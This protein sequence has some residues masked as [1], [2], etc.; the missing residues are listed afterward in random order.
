MQRRERQPPRVPLA[1]DGRAHGLLLL[2]AVRLA[3]AQLG[4]QVVAVRV[5]V[6]LDPGV[7]RAA[8][9]R[10]VPR[11][12]A[13]PAPAA[14]HP[15]AL[16]VRQRGGHALEERRERDVHQRKRL[17]Q[18]VGAGRRA[19]LGVHEVQRVFEP[20]PVLAVRPAAGEPAHPAA[21]QRA[22]ELEQ[23]RRARAL[24]RAVR[25]EHGRLGEGAFQRRRNGGG[26][27]DH[28]AVDLHHRQ[29]PARHLR[30][31]RRLLV[32]VA[33][34]VDL[35]HAVR[36]PLLLELHPDLL[37]VRAPRRV[38]AVKQHAR[39]VVGRRIEPAEKRLRVGRAVFQIVHRGEAV[40]RPELGDASLERVPARSVVREG[41]THERA[42]GAG[43]GARRAL[44]RLG[45]FASESVQ[46]RGEPTPQPA[47]VGPDDR[48]GGGR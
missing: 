43:G 47:R 30:R 38:V 34:H 18:E 3:P 27:G 39:L 8:R 22:L 41:N 2:V 32:A 12:Q 37:A 6:A 35:V 5:V 20:A 21:E 24:G 17:A 16:V 42:R 15:E 19:E 33:P 31:E 40:L 48:P 4:G 11:V 13:D 29:H 23:L 36:D 28:R 14:L 44:H 46:R 10:R 45:R 9:H 26:V 7:R 25:G 1:V